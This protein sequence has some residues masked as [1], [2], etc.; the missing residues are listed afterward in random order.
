VLRAPDSQGFDCAL[1]EANASPPP[2]C[3]ISSHFSSLGRVSSLP[4]APHLLTLPNSSPC[5]ACWAWAPSLKATGQPKSSPARCSVVPVPPS[6]GTASPVPASA[7]PLPH[8]GLGGWPKRR[9]HRKPGSPRSFGRE[10]T[11]D[12]LARCYTTGGYRNRAR[13]A[14]QGPKAGGDG[15]GGPGGVTQEHLFHV[16]HR[17]SLWAAGVLAG[18]GDL[19]RTSTDI[20][21]KSQHHCAGRRRPRQDSWR[22]RW[23]AGTWRREPCHLPCSS[24]LTENMFPS[25]R[26]DIPRV[27]KRGSQ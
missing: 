25:S 24:G 18:R 7:G 10:L 19:P 8:P 12:R 3:T 5:L 17:L 13:Q 2:T 22:G 1:S 9:G 26:A 23:V 20:S 4:T 27:Q 11:G 16:G 6:A 15:D 21:C 14:S